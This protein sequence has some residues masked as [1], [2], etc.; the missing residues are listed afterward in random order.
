MV[1]ALSVYGTSGKKEHAQDCPEHTLSQDMTSGRSCASQFLKHLADGIRQ[2][3][4][5]SWMHR[6]KALP[7]WHR[8]IV[9]AMHLRIH[10]LRV[11]GEPSLRCRVVAAFQCYPAD[12]KTIKSRP[13]GD[14][15][16]WE[17]SAMRSILLWILEVPVPVILLAH[18]I[19]SLQ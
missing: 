17:A 11:K 16:P 12:H 6:S 15:D 18:F 13:D 10:Q 8:G 2:A 5:R 14:D 7:A 19:N 3:L 1:Q 9:D 4:P